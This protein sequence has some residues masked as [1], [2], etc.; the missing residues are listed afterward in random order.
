MTFSDALT[1]VQYDLRKEVHARN[2]ATLAA[3]AKEHHDQA[4]ATTCV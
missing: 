2:G 1:T 3:A 4:P